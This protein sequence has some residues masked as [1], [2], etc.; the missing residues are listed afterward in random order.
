MKKIIY[1]IILGLCFLSKAQAQIIAG[2][3]FWNI[4]PGVG[5]A[6]AF[7]APEIATGAVDESFALNITT[8]ALAGQQILYVRF[9]QNDTL[10]SQAYPQSLFISPENLLAGAVNKKDTLEAKTIEH[11]WNDA[12]GSSV[13]TALPASD[14]NFNLTVGLSTSGATIGNN[15]FNYRIK[16]K[17]GLWTGWAK[18]QILVM[19]QLPIPT[20]DSIKFAIKPTKYNLTG[21]ILSVNFKD[22]NDKLNLAFNSIPSDLNAVV[23]SKEI[24]T[25]GLSHGIHI[26]SFRAYANNDV[27]SEITA[28]DTSALYQMAVMV[29]NT[30][31][32]NIGEPRLASNVLS[33]Q[34]CPGGI[35]K[36]PIDTTGNWP[37]NHPGIVPTFAVKLSN[38]VGLNFVTISSQMNNAGD[39]LVATIPANNALGTGFKIMVESTLPMIRDTASSTLTIG[40]IL[41]ASATNP[42][43]CEASTLNLAVSSN[44]A[45]AY[46]WTGPAA[47]TGSGAAPARLNIP[48]NGGGSYSVSS[49]STIAGC[50]ATATVAVTVNLLP[51][52]ILGSNTPVCEGQTLNLTSTS[53]GNTFGF[54]A[55]D[56]V[57]IGGSA[58]NKSIANVA[59]SDFGSYTVSYTSPASCVNTSSTSVTIKPLPVLSGITTNAPICSGNTLNFGLSATNLSTFAWTGPNSFTSTTANQSIQTAG[60]NTSGTYSVAVTLDGC[61][62]NTTIVNIV[63]QTPVAT[64]TTP[65]NI[66]EASSLQLNINNTPS[67]TYAWTGPLTFSSS[68]EDPTVSAL[69]TPNMSGAY[70]VTVTLGTCSATSSASVTVKPLPVLS[71]ITTNAPICSGN[72]LTFGLNSTVGSTY[73]WTGPDGFSSTA[74][75]QSINAAGINRS[76]T[77]SVAVTLD[78]CV[79]NTTIVNIV[80]QTPVA[81]VTTPVNICEASSLQLNIN[82]TPSATYAWTGPL[83]FSSSAEDPIVSALA[84]PNMSGAY[85]VT[86][87]LGTCS[88]TSSASVTVKPLP[89]LSGI[90]TNAPICSG[91]TLNFGLSATIGSTFAWIGPNSFTSTTANQS[92]Q[93]AGTN[94]SGTY[95]V[96]VTLDGCVV[97]T[98]IVNIVNQTPVATVTT[99]V[100]ICEASSLQLNINNTPLATYAW[101]GPLAFSSSAE[102][103]IVSALA[104]PNMS[105]TY[106]VTV[107]LGTCS[108]TSS[109][110]VTVKPLPVLSGI[111][112]NAP[113]CSGNTLTFGLN[114]T[115]GSTYSWIGPDGFSSTT[116]DQS[117][118]AAG[119]NRS[120]TYSVEVTLDGCMVNTTIVN[121]VNQTPAATVAS[122]VSICAATALQLNINNTPSATYAW[123]G[124]LA[125]S[126]SAEDPIVANNAAVNRTGTY[127]VTV[128]L[129]T[130]SASN[131]VQVTVNAVPVLVITN[132]SAQQSGSV[133]LT[134]AAVTLGSTLPP[135]TVLGYFTDAG[136]NNALASPTNVTVSGTYYIKATAPGSCIVIMAVVVNICGGVFDP[137]TAPI[138]SGTV[139]NV[140][141]QKISATNI[142]S[143]A[144][145]NVTYRSTVYVELLPGFIANAGTIFLSQIG[146]C[147]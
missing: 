92:I 141:T 26:L 121:I 81:T 24:T 88:A 94:T 142:I 84:A 109:A 126:S 130:C 105:G 137:I 124:P 123:A 40:L 43:V 131:T 99:P 9:K 112:T 60:T 77:Y 139:T 17:F 144:G 6:T 33:T 100:N 36:I 50:T 31:Q 12:S 138:S 106:L 59:L 44:V 114:S 69:A 1:L 103:P 93:T 65:V 115:V 83:T 132:Q 75:D 140:S 11:Y 4:D 23:G 145:T 10:W 30:I 52:I 8:P 97:N 80:N 134:L 118:N 64:V 5:L 125:F 129:G 74:E 54:W 108:A 35:I 146:G 37:R 21:N 49:V 135:G 58:G 122:P 53:A 87:T 42:T 3:Y 90:N 7:T 28:S 51:V 68:A 18:D 96:A 29:D 62:V 143:G 120:G 91:N 86:V 39:T 63:N 14:A 136:G 111:T 147:L 107:T 32:M 15:T 20:L 71:G 117:I 89:V 104:A 56:N 95:S 38:N 127:S 102:D 85:L 48:G 55:K 46:S 72:T 73:S 27:V 67:A 25:V 98:T 76:G 57:N 70:L 110:S 16:D 47:Y 22:A 113:I 78:G 61:V 79:V 133:N 41:T 45:A 13:L 19:G 116:E 2:E 82:N 66:C 128:T 101:T 34:F 119:I